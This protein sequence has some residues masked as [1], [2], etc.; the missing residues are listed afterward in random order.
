MY[1]GNIKAMY[2]TPGGHI[3]VCVLDLKEEE[4]KEVVKEEEEKQEEE[5]SSNVMSNL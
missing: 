1:Q 5:Q 3:F 4:E 2:L